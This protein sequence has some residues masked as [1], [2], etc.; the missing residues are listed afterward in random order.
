MAWAGFPPN[1]CPS[2][3]VRKISCSTRSLFAATTC[4]INVQAFKVSHLSPQPKQSWLALTDSNF[5]APAPSSVEFG[6]IVVDEFSTLENGLGTKNPP[7]QRR[8]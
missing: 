7:S 2:R 3:G 5:D 1:S 6:G 4:N 8:E